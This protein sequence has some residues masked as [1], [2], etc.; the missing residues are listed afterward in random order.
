MKLKKAG[1][2]ILGAFA[3]VAPI[4]VAAEQGIPPVVEH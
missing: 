1:V 4:A 3:F 2:Y